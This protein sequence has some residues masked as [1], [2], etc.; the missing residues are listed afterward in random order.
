[1]SA[2]AKCVPPAARRSMAGVG[3]VPPKGEKASARAA[4]SRM[5]STS[6]R[7]SRPEAM[8]WNA[9]DQYRSRAALGSPGGPSTTA[10]CQVTTALPGPPTPMRQ[11]NRFDL[12]TAEVDV[13]VMVP[14]GLGDPYLAR[15]G[16][17]RALVQSLRVDQ[18][19]VDGQ[20][21]ADDEPKARPEAGSLGQLANHFQPTR[22][23]HLYGAGDRC[24]ARSVDER[25]AAG[26]R[27]P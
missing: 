16:A 2:C 9:P 25:D 27:G 17:L 8:G 22:R 26:S 18:D 10:Q 21:P 4:S 3:R 1:M 20:L 11:P 23:G 24:G 5:T 6:G 13:E 7:P 12:A 14:E 19:R 15:D